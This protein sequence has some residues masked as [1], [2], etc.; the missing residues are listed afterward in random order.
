[1][2]KFLDN[3]LPN[4]VVNAVFY[5]I[6]HAREVAAVTW[7]RIRSV[8]TSQSICCPQGVVG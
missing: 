7:P 4:I 2:D 1:M 6:Q 8:E 3:W 5:L